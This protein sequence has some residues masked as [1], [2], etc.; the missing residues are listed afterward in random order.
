MKS[1]RHHVFTAFV[2]AVLGTAACSIILA[3]RQLEWDIDF[4]IY[5]HQFKAKL[6]GIQC[7]PL[8]PVEWLAFS[9][10]ATLGFYHFEEVIKAVEKAK[11]D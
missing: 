8:Y 4:D 11:D 5:G 2:G 7:L 9:S 3:H 6:V 10:A 1:W